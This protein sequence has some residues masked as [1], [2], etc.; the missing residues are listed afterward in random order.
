ML[1]ETTIF[2]SIFSFYLPEIEHLHATEALPLLVILQKCVCIRC[3]ATRPSG[4]LQRCLRSRSW[5]WVAGL[6]WGERETERRG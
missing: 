5:I 6:H 4:S 3:S 2:V 1:S